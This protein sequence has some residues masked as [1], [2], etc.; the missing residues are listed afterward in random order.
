MVIRAIFRRSKQNKRMAGQRRHM[1]KL[2][3]SAGLDAL[4][5]RLR[6]APFLRG[7]LERRA[8][9]GLCLIPHD[10]RTGDPTIASDLY[11][12]AFSLG[13]VRVDTDAFSPFIIKPPNRFWH[14]ELLGFSWLRHLRAADNDISRLHARSLIL[15]WINLQ[16]KTR[17]ASDDAA[18]LA[19][20]IISWLSHSPLFLDDAE[21]DFYHKTMKNFGQQIRTL[22][23]EI[24]SAP[25]GYPRLLAAIALCFASLCLNG[26]EKLLERAVQQLEKQLEYQILPDGGHISRHPGVGMELLLD[27]LPLR[28]TFSSRDM[29][30]PQ[31][32]LSAIDRMM[33]MVRFFRHGSGDFALF[34]GMGATNPGD[35]AAVLAL[36]DA[37]GRPILNAQHSGYQRIEAG[38][39]LVLMDAGAPPPAAVSRQAHAGCLSFE[40][41]SAQYQ[42][43]TNCGAPFAL[44]AKWREAARSTAAHSTCTIEGKSSCEFLTGR[45]AKLTG[46]IISAGPENVRVSRD[47]AGS[48]TVIEA[49]HDGYLKTFGTVHV[50][51][52]KLS[53]AGGLL[54]GE[55]RLT[56]ASSR[57][58]VKA[59]RELNA[60]LRFHLHPGITAAMSEDQKSVSLI[61]PNKEGWRFSTIGQPLALE[62][63]V[64]LA[65]T[66][67]P[68]PTTQIILPVKWSNEII[69]KWSFRRMSAGASGVMNIRPGQKTE[70]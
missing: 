39:T 4:G 46:Q 19:R 12:G 42:I 44:G 69:I 30:P 34:N 65:S 51:R 59:E 28:Q 47:E 57:R 18:V 23:R 50:R 24:A 11:R 64:F 54:E 58:P 3:T 48:E 13:G 35:T 37:H 31:I 55:D 20:R 1:L 8:P 29:T 56:H 14:D 15:D 36:D 17:A 43:I 16:H 52:L 21:A 40:L 9:D 6:A 67:G 66:K 7:P 45:L 38:N 53:T 5:A 61:L 25:E 33:P 70:E 26:Q 68:Q 27:L 41:S 22:N 49:S 10:L 62:E 63:S 2:A 32:L 60:V